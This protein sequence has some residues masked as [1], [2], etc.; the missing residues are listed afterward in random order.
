MP[1]TVIVA[2]D[3]GH[4]TV[5][6]MVRA[7][8]ALAERGIRRGA[9]RGRDCIFPIGWCSS[10]TA[11]A[12][13]RCASAI[14][15][16]LRE[17]PWVGAFIDWSANAPPMVC[18]TA[19]TLWNGRVRRPSPTPR[20]SC[21]PTPGRTAERAWRRRVARLPGTPRAGRSRA[22]ARPDRRA[23][24]AHSTHGTLSPRDQR[25]VLIVGGH[26]ARPGALDLPAGVIDIAPTILALLGL[27]PLPDA[28]GRAS[29]R[30][31]PT[32]HHP[33]QLSDQRNH[34]NRP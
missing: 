5:T 33:V 28:D 13:R 1:T 14:G 30:P 6:G 2:S 19:A 12:R 18:L 16:W 25:T 17:Q 10:R 27:P 4:S 15:A 34:I 26:K 3:H 21:T 7:D 24:T 29:P 8:N 22:A 9:R 11:P 32:A 31:S 20:P 23:R